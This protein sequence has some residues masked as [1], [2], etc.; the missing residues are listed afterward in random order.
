M[1]TRGLMIGRNVESWPTWL[2]DAVGVPHALLLW[3][4]CWLWWPKSD[5]ELRRFGYLLAYLIVFYLIFVRK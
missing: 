3:M 1:Y 4:K 5:K 2:Q